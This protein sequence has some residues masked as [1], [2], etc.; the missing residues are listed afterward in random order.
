MNFQNRGSESPT[1]IDLSSILA[2]VIFIKLEVVNFLRFF[3]RTKNY[4]FT[5]VKILTK[6]IFLRIKQ[7]HIFGKINIENKA[8]RV[9][10]QN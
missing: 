10:G 4:Q 5:I 6:K 3:F 1:R 8:L 7:K 9:F 2:A